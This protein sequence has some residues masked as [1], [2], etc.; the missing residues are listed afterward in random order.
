MFSKNL[1]QIRKVETPYLKL[2]G[3][4][5]EEVLQMNRPLTVE[6]LA[7]HVRKWFEKILATKTF[8][9]R[10][11]YNKLLS[12]KTSAVIRAVRA[13]SP[14]MDVTLEINL[15]KKIEEKCLK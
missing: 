1:F 7:E 6:Q 4:T 15:R 3:K 8:V 13:L 5:Y 10:A 9:T 14:S 11:S 12:R 2:I